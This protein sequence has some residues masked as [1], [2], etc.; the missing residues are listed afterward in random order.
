M[1]IDH[2]NIKNLAELTEATQ[3]VASELCEKSTLLEVSD[4]EFEP[5]HAGSDSTSYVTLRVWDNE[6][7]AQLK[8][9]N[10]LKE[11]AGRVRQRPALVGTFSDM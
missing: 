10:P 9:W 3:K 7:T 5:G 6:F 8:L 1:P 11:K 2:P 4:H